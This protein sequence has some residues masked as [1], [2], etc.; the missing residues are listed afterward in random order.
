MVDDPLPLSSLGDSRSVGLEPVWDNY[1]ED[2]PL[3]LP[4][5]PSIILLAFGHKVDDP[6]FNSIEAF[7]T[8]HHTI[9]ALDWFQI[10]NF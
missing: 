4:I 6:L 7:I 8:H 9:Y 1:C 3:R 10:Y 5:Y 2:L